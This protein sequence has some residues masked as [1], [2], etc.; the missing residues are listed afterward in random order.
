MEFEIRPATFADAGAC[1]AILRSLP[2]WF[3]IE[4]AISHIA[5]DVQRLP[6]LIAARGG[7]V[8]GFLSLQQHNAYTTEIHVMAVLRAYHRCGIG[9]A[10]VRRAEEAGRAAGAEYLEVKTL[11]PSKPDEH[12]AG[13]RAFYMRCGFLPLEEFD[14]IWPADPCLIMVR[15]LQ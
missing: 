6:T 11:G 4:E 9:T 14:G 8:L 13:T 2:E 5:E 3:G 12:Y 1:E 15:K 7:Q 10:L